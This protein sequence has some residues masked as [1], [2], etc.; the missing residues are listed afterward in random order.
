MRQA[1]ARFATSGDPNGAGLPHWPQYDRA[2]DPY[3]EFGTRVQAGHAYRKAQ[4]DVLERYY[5]G[6]HP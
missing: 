3:L 2:R 6:G 1:W 4:L 5:T